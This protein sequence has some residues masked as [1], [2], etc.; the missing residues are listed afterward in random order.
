MLWGLRKGSLG[1]VRVVARAALC[2]SLGSPYINRGLVGFV[3]SCCRLAGLFYQD[4]FCVF[5]PRAWADFRH[6]GLGFRVLSLRSSGV[7]SENR[8]LAWV[9]ANWRDLGCILSVPI[10]S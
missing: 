10:Q 4:W 2:I 3:R 5:G 6:A 8:I 1:V 9:Q 7:G